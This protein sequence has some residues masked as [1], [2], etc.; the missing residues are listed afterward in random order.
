MSFIPKNQLHVDKH[1]SQVA[2]NY[3]P[4]GQFA[5]RIAPIV[6]VDKQTDLIKIWSQADIW[7]IDNT[8]RAPGNEANRMEI[9]VS[10]VQYVC[11]NYALA[12][13][14]TV[15]DRAN[16]DP[17]FVRELET[18]RVKTLSWKMSMDWDRRVAQQVTNT[19]NVGTS[20]NVGS[21]W[22]DLANS[23]PFGDINT[24]IDNV[25]DGTGFRPNKMLIGGEAFRYLVRNDNIIDKTKETALTGASMNTTQQRIADLFELDDVIVGKGY[26]NSA[27]EGQP[28]SLTRTLD[29]HVLLYYA[30]STPSIEVPSFMYTFRWNVPGVPSMQVERIPFDP[31]RKADRL[32]IGYYQDEKIVSS[33]LG[34]LVTNVTSSQ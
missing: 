23:D 1:L 3:Q 19:S 24:I 16:A 33:A 25:E 7:R 15:E 26:F 32:Q 4:Q 10:S 31:R 28:L 20:A 29:P 34:G 5:D 2:L 8:V 30:P 9:S 14:I 17:S 11:K 22:T 13:D 27:Q 12:A 21:S 18:G 6:N